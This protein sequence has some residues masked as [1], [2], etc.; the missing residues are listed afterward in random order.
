MEEYRA[1]ATDR[2]HVQ[3]H[4]R[5]ASRGTSTRTDTRTERCTSTKKAPKTAARGQLLGHAALPGSVSRAPD[6]VSPVKQRVCVYQP[7]P[8]TA[9]GSHHNGLGLPCSPVYPASRP[10]RR[11]HPPP[12]ALRHPQPTASAPSQVYYPDLFPTPPHS[13]VAAQGPTRS[14]RPL[15]T[16]CLEIFRGSFFRGR[17]FRCPVPSF[18]P[19]VQNLPEAS[20]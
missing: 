14:P 8:P 16:P 5:G 17:N 13:Q 2:P 1:L 9:L 7:P 4:A 11:Q 15:A 19:L 18:A 3:T 20:C 6:S 10:T 12:P